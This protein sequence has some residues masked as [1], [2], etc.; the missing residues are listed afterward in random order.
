MLS[1]FARFAFTQLR[2]TRSMFRSHVVGAHT[3]AGSRRDPLGHSLTGGECGAGRDPAALSLSPAAASSSLGWTPRPQP[4]QGP[5]RNLSSPPRMFSLP[6]ATRVLLAVTHDVEI[7]VSA[8]ELGLGG[9]PQVRGSN[10]SAYSR[11][12]LS[13]AIFWDH[14]E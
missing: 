8:T 4:L 14:P 1:K 5:E 3:G 9:R 13:L 10:R 12:F 11:P 2:R 6:A 7:P